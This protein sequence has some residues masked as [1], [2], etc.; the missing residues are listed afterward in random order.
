MIESRGG[1]VTSTVSKKT[2]YV[3][4]GDEAGSKL[5]K[6]NSLGVTVLDESGFKGMLG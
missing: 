6:A 4:A 5:E 1:R 3:I 2:G